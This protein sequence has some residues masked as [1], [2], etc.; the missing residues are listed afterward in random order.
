ML[1]Y[2]SLFSKYVSFDI[3]YIKCNFPVISNPSASLRSIH[4]LSQDLIEIPAR[5]YRR[6]PER[7]V[8]SPT[9]EAFPGAVKRSLFPSIRLFAHF[10]FFLPSDFAFLFTFPSFTFPFIFLLSFRPLFH[11]SSVFLRSVVELRIH[12]YMEHHKFTKPTRKYMITFA[13]MTLDSQGTDLFFLF[14][15]FLFSSFF[16]IRPS[17]YGR[18]R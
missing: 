11:F 8:A 1:L 12:R 2:I 16:F 6:V 13:F 4:L 10:I 7:R 9:L 5:R 15:A 18:F 17:I 3:R 14:A